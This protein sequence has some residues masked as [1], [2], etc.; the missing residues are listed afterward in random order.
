L[1]SLF[2]EVIEILIAETKV[3]LFVRQLLI[4]VQRLIIILGSKTN[5]P[6]TVQ[7]RHT[8]SPREDWQLASNERS[9]RRSSAAANVSCVVNITLDIWR[10]GSSYCGDRRV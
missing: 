6:V 8:N 3:R 10:I 1:S 9:T 4:A 7:S 5:S 2:S